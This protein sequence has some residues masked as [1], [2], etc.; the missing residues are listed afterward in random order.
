MEKGFNWIE[1]EAMSGPN[2]L[3]ILGSIYGCF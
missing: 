2:N 1:T 3:S